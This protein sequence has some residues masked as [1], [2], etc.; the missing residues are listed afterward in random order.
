MD[1]AASNRGTFR[2]SRASARSSRPPRAL[3]TGPAMSSPRSSFRPAGTANL[4]MCP[5]PTLI[6]PVRVLS[7]G[8]DDFAECLNRS[9]RQHRRGRQCAPPPM[10]TIQ[11]RYMRAD[12]V[13]PLG[14]ERRLPLILLE[15]FYCGHITSRS[16]GSAHA[17]TDSL[18]KIPV[19]AGGS[20]I[21]ANG[22]TTGWGLHAD[23]CVCSLNCPSP[24]PLTLAQ[25]E[26]LG[27]RRVDQ[28][29]L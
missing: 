24:L 25:P 9:D 23:L 21:F 8:F 18:V 3:L 17:R 7:L 28:L 16:A 15:T 29:R 22:D 5:L 4:I 1:R 26:W 2:L 13:C 27:S 20:Y 11:N 19:D 12:Q 6:W 14:Y 10:L